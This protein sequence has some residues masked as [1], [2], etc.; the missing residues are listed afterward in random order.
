MIDTNVG[1]IGESLAYAFLQDKGYRIVEKHFTSH[2]GEIDLIVQKQQK[3]IFVEVKTRVGDRLGLPHE[4]VR[5]YKIRG[6][7]RAIQHYL[8]NHNCKSYKM[9]VDVIGIL[10]KQDLSVESI[11]HYENVEVF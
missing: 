1:K 4:S 8:L 10:L 6:L 9:A 2:W 11:K 5:F 7:K 3:L